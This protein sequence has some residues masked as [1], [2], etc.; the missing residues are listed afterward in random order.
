MKILAHIEV[1]KVQLT[2]STYTFRSE[3][4]EVEVVR[5]FRYRADRTR[6]RYYYHADVKRPARMHPEARVG[7]PG[8]GLVRVNVVRKENPGWKPPTFAPGVK[9]VEAS[10]AG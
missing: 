1:E 8:G 5:V 9:C 6:E 4:M 2:P 10:D 7:Y 3:Q